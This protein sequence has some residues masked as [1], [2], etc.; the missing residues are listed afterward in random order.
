MT[1]TRS[2]DVAGGIGKTAPLRSPNTHGHAH[3]VTS[4]ATRFV[5]TLPRLPTL[6]CSTERRMGPKNTDRGPLTDLILGGSLARLQKFVIGLV[7]LW[8][9]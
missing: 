6:T 8:E 5:Y 7:R 2:R 9:P 4:P 1:R 3:D